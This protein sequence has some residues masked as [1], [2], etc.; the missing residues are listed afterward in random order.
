MVP[1]P[2]VDGWCSSTRECASTCRLPRRARGEQHRRGGRG[3]THAVGGDRRAAGTAWCRRSRAS[4]WS[5]R[6]GEL[7]YSPISRSGAVRLEVEQLRHHDV[8]DTVVD[9][10]TQEDDP[11]VEQSAEDVEGPFACRGPLDD[12]GNRVLGHG[13]QPHPS[14]GRERAR[15]R[16]NEPT[17]AVDDPV[18]AGLLGGEPAVP[19]AVARRS[20][21]PVR[22][23]S[24]A[25]ISSDCRFM[26]S[27]F[28]AWMA[29]SIAVPPMPADGWCIMIRL[30]ARLIRLPWVP[31]ASSTWPMLAANPMATVTTS[32]GISFMVS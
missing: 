13:S 21:R 18:V 12:V 26:Y 27:Q 17:D 23:V 9:L 24:A 25:R 7:M 20:P 1:W 2:C 19:V 30:C 5:I 3:L 16:A 29:M 10:G 32:L 31:E 6:P 28:S 8:R 14:G 11:L 15:S 4:R 22:P